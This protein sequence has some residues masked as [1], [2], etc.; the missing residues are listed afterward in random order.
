MLPF[1]E[2]PVC[3]GEIVSKQVEKLLRGG[4]NS[5]GDSASGG[6]PALRGT[7]VLERDCQ[8]L[9]TDS[10]KT[11]PPGYNRISS[12]RSIVSSRTAAII[13]RDS[14]RT[15]ATAAGRTISASRR[16]ASL[17]YGMSHH[18]SLAAKITRDKP[19]GA[20]SYE[21]PFSA[22]DRRGGSRWHSI[23]GVPAPPAAEDYHRVPAGPH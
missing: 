23:P 19:C 7:F 9:R 10:R 4:V 15:L 16:S 8:S 17:D 20:F 21:V 22:A 2:C 6:V 12:P 11:G 13:E 5:R 1:R 14:N 18:H 3:G